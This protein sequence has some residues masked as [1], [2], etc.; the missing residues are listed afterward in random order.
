MNPV[1][2][3]IVF[4]GMALVMHGI[5]AEKVRALEQHVRVEYRFI[6]RTIYE[7]QMATTDLAG[8]FKTMFGRTEPW[9]AG[10]DRGGADLGPQKS[11][12]PASM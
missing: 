12:S 3:L 1:V 7:E 9:L 4:V 6:P 11:G 8:K 10:R 2:V 5:Y